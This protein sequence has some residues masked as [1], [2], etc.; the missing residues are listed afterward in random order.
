MAC[1]T[2]SCASVAAMIR[3]GLISDHATVELRGG[4]L[5]VFWDREKDILWM[6]GP[7]ETVFEGEILDGI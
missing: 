4:S 6:D 1:G 3:K 7:A 2:G 5:S